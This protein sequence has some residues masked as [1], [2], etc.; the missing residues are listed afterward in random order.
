[1]SRHHRRRNGQSVLDR[2]LALAYPDPDD[3]ESARRAFL[4]KTPH[5]RDEIRRRLAEAFETT[6]GNQ[7][8]GKTP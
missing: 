2:A 8:H 6:K 4:R 7:D 5:E 1:M 3:R